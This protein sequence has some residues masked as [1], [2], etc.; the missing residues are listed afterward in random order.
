MKELYCLTYLNLSEA[1]GNIRAVEFSKLTAVS[2]GEVPSYCVLGFKSYCFIHISF[3]SPL[4][5]SP[6][7]GRYRIMVLC[8]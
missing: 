5:V 8:F 7:M 2:E 1:T 4:C 6:G 3:E